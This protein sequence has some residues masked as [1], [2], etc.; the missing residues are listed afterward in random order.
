MFSAKPVSVFVLPVAYL[1]TYTLISEVLT[2][3]GSWSMLA[4]VSSALC[5]LSAAFSKF[6]EMISYSKGK[7]KVKGE[8]Q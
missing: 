1:F 4:P 8:V 7:A 5:T 6:S 2:M 3:M